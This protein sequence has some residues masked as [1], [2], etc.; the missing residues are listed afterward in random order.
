ML[1]SAHARARDGYDVVGIV[2]THGRKETAALL[3]GVEI[4]PCQRLE[5]KGQLL[6]EMDLEAIIARRPQIVPVDELA[7]T[8]A[9]GSRH[10]KRYLD[11]EL[12]LSHGIDVYSTV[13][14]Q[15]IESRNDVVARI[16]DVRVRAT[17]PAGTTV[18]IQSWPDRDSIGLQ[19]LDQGAG[20]LPGDLKQI[21]DKFY[22]AHKV[23]QVRAGAGLGLAISRGFIE[24]MPATISAANRIDR[25]GAV[26]TIRLP[27]PTQVKQ[28]DTAA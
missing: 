3:E 2:E 28:L 7:R 18:R 19:V 6:E 10:P 20:T 14:I 8:N 11:V 17:V 27:V 12:L 21:F 16:T 26:F 13:N 9:A 23:D 1:Q 25:T 24:A 5:Y 4:I 15:H 22:R